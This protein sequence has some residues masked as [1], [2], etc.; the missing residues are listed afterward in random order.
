[1]RKF[2]TIFQA[3]SRGGVLL[4]TKA[5]GCQIRTVIE[6][7]TD[8]PVTSEIQIVLFSLT[9][10]QSAGFPLLYWFSWIKLDV[11]AI[12]MSELRNRSIK[13]ISLTTPED[14][15]SPPFPAF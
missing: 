2:E 11:D 12:L 15:R 3:Q 6:R 8:F 10:V 5:W 14:S 13:T 4:A 1:M 9:T 7:R